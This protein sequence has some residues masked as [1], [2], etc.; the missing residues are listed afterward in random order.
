MSIQ[1]RPVS[2]R[3]FSAHVDKLKNRILKVMGRSGRESASL[4]VRLAVEV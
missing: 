3:G 2:K 4:S 1:A